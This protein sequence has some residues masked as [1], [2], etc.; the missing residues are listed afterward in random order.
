LDDFLTTENLS[1]RLARTSENILQV[2]DKGKVTSVL[3]KVENKL[4]Q[5]KPEKVIYSEIKLSEKRGTKKP[6]GQQDEKHIVHFDKDNPNFEPI[7]DEKEPWVMDDYERNSYCLYQNKKGSEK[8]TLQLIVGRVQI[9][10]QIRDDSKNKDD[11]PNNGEPFLE[12]IW[13][14]RK[15]LQVENFEYGTDDG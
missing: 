14:N 6:D 13:T 10:H 7:V 15:I 1:A 12:Y 2:D 11:L 4:K 3:K 8:E 5:M 9:W